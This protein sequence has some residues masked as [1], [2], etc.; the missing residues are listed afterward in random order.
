[1]SC[2]YGIFA[3]FRFGFY[4]VDGNGYQIVR[5]RNS[6]ARYAALNGV[7]RRNVAFYL[8]PI[9]NGAR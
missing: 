6:A 3:V 7:C 5:K 2:G 8:D 9:F 1:M 4:E